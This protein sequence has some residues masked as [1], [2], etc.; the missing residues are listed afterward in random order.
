MKR[1]ARNFRLVKKVDSIF[2]REILSEIAIKFKRDDSSKVDDVA[3]EKF[4][5][6]RNDE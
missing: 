1:A 6:Y 2:V 5:F 4:R 3:K